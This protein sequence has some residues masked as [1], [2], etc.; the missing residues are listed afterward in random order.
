MFSN[1]FLNHTDEENTDEKMSVFLPSVWSFIF[2][3]I[4]VRYRPWELF[5]NSPQIGTIT[6]KK[7]VICPICGQD[8]HLSWCAIAHGN[9]C[10][11]V[12]RFAKSRYRFSFILG[13]PM[14]HHQLS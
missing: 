8:F 2:S 7:S 13:V 9:S 5:V 6:D 11:N 14:A 10:V 4:V 12:A 1:P 3:F